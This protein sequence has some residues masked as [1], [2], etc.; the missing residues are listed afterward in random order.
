MATMIEPTQPGK[1]E[2]LAAI[3]QNIDKGR[4]PFISRAKRA[5]KPT[6]TLMQWQVDNYPTPRTTGVLDG[7]DVSSFEY[8]G[9]REKI[10]NYI[11]FLRYAPGV[12]ELAQEVSD[13]AGLGVGQ[14]M[15]NQIT[16]SL[17]MCARSAEACCLMDGQDAQAQTGTTPYATRSVGKWCATTA[18][19]VQPIPSDYLP[20]AGNQDNTATAS[21][22]EDDIVG[23]MESAAGAAKSPLDFVGFFGAT[24]RRAISKLQSYAPGSTIPLRR[25]QEMQGVLEQSV[26]KMANDFGTLELV[27][28][29]F[30]NIDTAYGAVRGYILDMEMFELAYNRMPRVRELPN[31]GGGPRAEV[32]MIFGLVCRNPL[33]ACYYN[34]T[35]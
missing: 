11:T 9:D 5:A 23:M 4:T 24:A 8:I 21:I 19:T 12:G 22:T 18:G 27:L 35:A 34:P 32:S 17:K 10:G 26:T 2:M 20:A 28:D 31:L 16:K 29:Y 1:R 13:V 15:A 14:E 25:T 6:N 30:V 3:I 33:T 7:S